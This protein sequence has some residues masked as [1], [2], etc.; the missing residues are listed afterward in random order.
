LNLPRERMFN[1]P[2]VVLAL[3]ALMALI[4]LGMAFGLTVAETNDLLRYVAFSP[5]R[6]MSD[7]PDSILPNGLGPRIWTFVSYAFVHLNLNHLI[8]NLLWL[9]AFGSPVARRFG[10]LR[11]LTLYFATAAAGALA[12]LAIYWGSV[13]PMIGASA[14]ISGAMGAAMRFVFQREGPLGLLGGSDEESY[15]VPAAPLTAM[16]LSRPRR[17][18]DCHAAR[19]PRGRVP[20]G[21]V[22]RQ[23]SV[24]ARHVCHAGAGRRRAGLGG[25]HRRFPRRPF[26]IRAARPHPDA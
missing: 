21:M 19:A 23:P 24:R 25:A 16:V 22:W 6:Y 18:T 17:A 4:H 7:I 13:S 8:F 12:H 9:V 26:G 2:P 14:A 10:A 1:V 15:R 3:V 5:L 11:F 20:R